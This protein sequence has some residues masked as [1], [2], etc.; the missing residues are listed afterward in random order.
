MAE[1]TGGNGHGNMFVPS[2]LQ[3]R[4]TQIDEIARITDELKTL[5]GRINE[6]NKTAGGKDDQ[7]AKAY[8]KYTD[9]HGKGLENGLKSLA[10]L[11]ELLGINGRSA[12]RTLDEAEHES[13]QLAHK[14]TGS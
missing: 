13:D 4:F 11:F 14:L 3:R 6:Q 1:G 5:T 10:E 7:Y 8:H 12:A 2:D 9:E